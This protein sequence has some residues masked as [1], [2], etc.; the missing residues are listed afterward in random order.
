LL[1]K[2]KNYG[3]SVG[4]LSYEPKTRSNW[5]THPKGHV[6]I[7]IEGEGFFQEKCKPARVIKKGDVVNAAEN[8]EHWNGASATSKM[9]DIAIT[10]YK[11]DE[12]VIWLQP[13]T[14]ADYD[15]VNAS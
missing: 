7:I 10:H 14:D 15:N 13:V 11:G 3:F 9:I 4:S 8:V 12:Q 1:A 6:L 5:H 2:D